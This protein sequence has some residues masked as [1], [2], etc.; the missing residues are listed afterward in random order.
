MSDKWRLGL[1]FTLLAAAGF[2]AWKLFTQEAPKSGL[3]TT[4]RSNNTDGGL[5]GW[6]ASLSS[7]DT[8]A[9]ADKATAPAAA[10]ATA[11]K[12]NS[13]RAAAQARAPRLPKE[14]P[15]DRTERVKET[16]A[17][18]VERVPA[19]KTEKPARVERVP[20]VKPVR[21]DDRTRAGRE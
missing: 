7:S 17:A 15:L 19:M 10:A 20:K 14:K 3:L 6:L 21:A 16:R 9:Q 11:A 1:I 4:P 8:A 18:K 2:G 5:S 13:A 12:G